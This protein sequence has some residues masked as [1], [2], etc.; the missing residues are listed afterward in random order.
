V[1][2]FK[3]GNLNTTTYTY[4]ATLGNLL[5]IQK[6]A[7]GGVV[8]TITNAYNARGQVTSVIDETGIQTQNTYDTASEKLTKAIR[9]TNWLATV[10]GTVT[11]G[12]IL[13]LTAHD[14]LLSGG[15]E[16]VTYTVKTGDTLRQLLRGLLLQ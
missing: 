6:P 13:T 9:N 10:G 3:D 15:Q 7:V 5:K 12:N 2:T 14:A 11:V 1:K 16:A 8:P 4:D